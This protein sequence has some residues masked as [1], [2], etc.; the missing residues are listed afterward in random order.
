MPNVDV[1]IPANMLEAVSIAIGAG[2]KNEQ[3]RIEA[4]RR[5]LV[6]YVRSLYVAGDRMMRE[7]QT[8][9]LARDIQ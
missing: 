5:F 9:V 7:A 2:T 1:T 3:Q 8:N 6:D 4:V